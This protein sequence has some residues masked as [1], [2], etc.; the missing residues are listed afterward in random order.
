MVKYL[1]YLALCW[2]SLPIYAQTY[3]INTVPDPKSSPS[4]NFVSNPDAILSEQTVLQINQL[5]WQVED[6]TTAQVA[7]VALNSIG[8]ATPK[9]FAHDL[10]NHWGLGYAKKDNGLLILLVLDQRRVE[11]E[12]G[13]GME[14]IFTDA[15]CKRIQTQKMVPHFKNADYNTGVLE[16]VQS[17]SQILLQPDV[18]TD[19]YDPSKFD[20]NFGLPP[21]TGS[22]LLV[23][24]CM[25]VLALMMWV[26]RAATRSGNKVKEA[27]DRAVYKDPKRNLQIALLYFVLPLC[28][29]LLLLFS[30][31]LEQFTFL[32]VLPWV[33]AYILLMVVWGR[34]K[35]EEIFDKIYDKLPDASKYEHLSAATNRYWIDAILFP[36]PM[37][38]FWYQ[39]RQ[40]LHHLRYHPRKSAGGSELFL[41]SDA[42]KT[43]YLLAN[44]Q[45]E[46][47]LGTV[48]YD[49]W[50]N[51]A[52]SDTEV[53]G[54][55]DLANF[56]YER[57]T[58]CGSKT[59]CLDKKETTIRATVSAE[60]LALHHY[61]CKA[62]NYTR[63][64][65]VTLPKLPPPSTS[66]SGGSGGSSSSS[67]GSSW[68]GGSSGGGGS[69][70]SW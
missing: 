70:S 52:Q 36:I 6:S 69:G 29:G 66:G 4:R 31:V 45:K 8:D 33:Y 27:I 30:D 22:A 57:C 68:G 5:L 53:I 56:K 58:K 43:A 25:T 2:Y 67:G 64:K 60:G 55:E 13:Y 35:R 44:Q 42:E 7:V 61:V 41:L 10:F 59:Y 20:S 46:E 18:A 1:F 3:T 63:I 34:L 47:E 38:W 16:A 51:S 65:E 26:F 9:D 54:Y 12:T 24:F 17:I 39:N 50:Q 37:L 32:A 11:F 14:A 28:I 62:C 15:L 48:S 49:V 40:R 21:T 19:V 23:S